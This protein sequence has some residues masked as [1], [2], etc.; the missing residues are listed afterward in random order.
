MK[1]IILIAFLSVAVF[2]N[3]QPYKKEIVL[4]KVT[5]PTLVKVAL[6]NEI[7]KHA[8]NSYK[9]VRL[10][11]KSGVEG[12][13]IKSLSTKNIENQK[14]L[15]ATAYDRKDAKLTY[16][17]REPFDVE[18]ISLNIEDRNFES[19]VDVY[20]DGKVVAKNEKIFDYAS[21]TGTQNFTIKIAKK[22]VKELSIVYHLDE[23]TS[24]YKKYKNLKEMKKYLT[25]KSIRVSNSNK[26]EDVWN[27]TEVALYK[28]STDEE[29]KEKSYIFKTDNIPFSKIY[30]NTLEKNFKRSGQLFLSDDEKKWHSV[31]RFS[32]LE[33]SLNNQTH[34]FISGSHRA[35]YL[36]LVLFNADNK[37]LTIESLK[38]FTKPSYIYF[39]ASKNEKYSLYFGDKNLTKPFYELESLVSNSDI[40]IEAKF[41]K[42]E[43]LKVTKV[44]NKVSFFEVYKEQIFI[45]G[46][47]LAL[48]VLGYVAFGLLKRT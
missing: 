48:G 34:K 15:T 10:H 29:K 19:S 43:A 20:A 4:E 7:Y 5:K 44:S 9:D 45:F 17:F 27:K 35:K 8:T 13:F 24:F 46:M 21:E 16:T 30:V 32:I 28:S 22:K 39:I 14:T 12:Y 25:I 26:V 31:K 36:K 2:A 37:P 1:S 3:T 23:T 42:L 18:K 33:S 47:L 38:L 6:D 41:T 40:A 11:S